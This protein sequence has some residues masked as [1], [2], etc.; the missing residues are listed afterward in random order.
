MMQ[1]DMLYDYQSYLPIPYALDEGSIEAS[2]IVASKLVSKQAFKGLQKAGVVSCDGIVDTTKINKNFMHDVA[3]LASYHQKQV[4]DMLFWWEEET[5]RLKK[6]LGERKELESLIVCSSAEAMPTYAKLLDRVRK[7][8]DARPSQRDHLM[9]IDEDDLMAR[10]M[11]G[12][13]MELQH[14]RPPPDE[15]PPAYSR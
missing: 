6:L 1:K 14:A 2:M 10:A 5:M 4:I 15:L 9:E 11:S 3:V 13:M 8:I 7:K 12:G